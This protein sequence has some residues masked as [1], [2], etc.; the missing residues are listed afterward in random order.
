MKL[1]SQTD[2]S[3]NHIGLCLADKAGRTYKKFRD[4]AAWIP[5]VHTESSF[6]AR[7]RHITHPL[8]QH[9]CDNGSSMWTLDLLHLTDYHGLIAHA[10]GNLLAD[11][12]RDSEIPDCRT[13]GH[14][15]DFLNSNL[16][17]HYRRIE[18]TDRIGEHSIT[19]TL[20]SRPHSL[21]V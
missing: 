13:H 10:V 21:T 7:H 11:I 16:A 12:V 15:L 19:R 4:D 2:A 3:E 5:T 17:Q 6:R 14:T 18:A 8:V 20:C 9:I 1:T